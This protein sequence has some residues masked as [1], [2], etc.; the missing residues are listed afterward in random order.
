MPHDHTTPKV[1]SASSLL[2]PLMRLPATDILAMAQG[3]SDGARPSLDFL[4]Q[5]W[6]ELVDERRCRR[7]LRSELESLFMA[8]GVRPEPWLGAALRAAQGVTRTTRG[9][10]HLYVL[11]HD[12][13]DEDGAGA[14]L[15]VGRSRYLPK[16]RFAQHASGLAEKHAARRF[17]LNRPGTRYRLLALLPSLFAHLNPLSRAEAEVLEVTLVECMLAAGVPSARVGGPR[18]RTP[19]EM[20]PDEC[21][22]VAA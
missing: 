22:E 8:A 21:V 1:A 5:A 11:V 2:R 20:E 12:G 7:G 19:D 3:T 16:T 9:N 6:T 14:G 17:R 15:Y 4:V 18:D 13:F 10:H